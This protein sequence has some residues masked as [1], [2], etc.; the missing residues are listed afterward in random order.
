MKKH[1]LILDLLIT[2]LLTGC[3]TSTS[4]TDIIQLPNLRGYTKDEIENELDALSIEYTF[5]LFE[6]DVDVDGYFV[7]Y[8]DYDV[9]DDFNVTETLIVQIYHFTP[10]I[11]NEEDYFSLSELDYDGPF[12][13]NNFSSVNYLNPRGGYFEVTLN[14]CTDGDTAVFDYPTDVYNAIES[15]AKSTRF[16]NMDTE[17]T[18]SGGEEEWGKPASLYTCSLLKDAESIIIQTDPGDS[19]L[20]TYGRLLGWIWVQLPTEEE[21]FLL[22]YLVVQQGLAQVKYEFG[23]GETISYGDYTYNEWMHI[24]QDYAIENDLGQWSNLLDYYWDYD[25]DK[26]NYNRR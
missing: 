7:T 11:I 12:L 15:S 22:N 6:I 17:E 1:L 26:P 8:Q 13:D 24:A 23:A 19:L 21:Y 10:E 25:N 4:D 2:F 5:T 20:G 14:Y 18:F 9:N 3:N 16:L